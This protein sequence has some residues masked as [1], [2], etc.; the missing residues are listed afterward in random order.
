MIKFKINEGQIIIMF[1]EDALRNVLLKLFIG[2][3]IYFAVINILIYFQFGIPFTPREWLLN[4][5]FNL[6]IKPN[7]GAWFILLICEII[8]WFLFES[9][10]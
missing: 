5:L 3:I 2:L 9:K 8:G 10:R 7:I 6:F 4:P 1:D